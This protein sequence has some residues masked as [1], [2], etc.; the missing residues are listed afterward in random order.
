MA[1]STTWSAMMRASS[2]QYPMPP[3]APSARSR[4]SATLRRRR[5]SVMMIASSAH[6]IETHDARRYLERSLANG[7]PLAEEHAMSHRLGFDNCAF[8]AQRRVL[9]HIL[10][11]TRQTQG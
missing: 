2:L 3:N 11:F 7:A 5:L 9:Q 1:A 4:A 6:R 10:S 8:A